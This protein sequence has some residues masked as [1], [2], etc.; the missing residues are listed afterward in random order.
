M[1]RGEL[2]LG[3]QVDCRWLKGRKWHVNGCSRK[4][5][6]TDCRCDRY[7]SLDSDWSRNW[8]I[9]TSGYIG[10]GLKK[11]SAFVGAGVWFLPGVTDT[12]GMGMMI[13]RMPIG[14]GLRILI[15]TRLPSGPWGDCLFLFSLSLVQ[16]RL[17]N[18]LHVHERGNHGCHVKIISLGEGF[19]LAS[20]GFERLFAIP[21]NR[22]VIFFEICP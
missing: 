18:L 14:T 4:D 5:K 12:C 7:G 6:A 20:S 8:T 2:Q 17:L 19:P 21:D 15:I 3:R 16:I 11:Q 13:A 10:F 9:R 22:R 1:W